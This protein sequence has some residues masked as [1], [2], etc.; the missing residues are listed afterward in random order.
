MMQRNKLHAKYEESKQN[1][2]QLRVMDNFRGL[3][4]LRP[5]AFSTYNSLA[6]RP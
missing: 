5:F 6:F 2:L 3:L 1:V 4:T